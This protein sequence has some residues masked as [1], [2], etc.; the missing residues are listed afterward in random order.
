MY[1]FYV[2]N[3]IS[4]FAL[5]VSFLERTSLP[6]IGP[7]ILGCGIEVESSQEILKSS[8]E[9]GYSLPLLIFSYCL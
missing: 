8:F 5:K 4:V 7:R 3:C 6:H 9:I 1:I 2:L